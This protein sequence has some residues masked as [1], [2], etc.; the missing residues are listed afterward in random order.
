MME[1][2]RPIEGEGVGVGE[3][4]RR[5]EAIAAQRLERPFG[6]Q[7]I[8]GADADAGERSAMDAVVAARQAQ[9]LDLRLARRVVK[10]EIDRRGVRRINRD[11][12]RLRR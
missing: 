2:E 4:L 10:A 11:L 12:A 5:I 7:A 3:Q 6:A 1:A 8:A 9:T